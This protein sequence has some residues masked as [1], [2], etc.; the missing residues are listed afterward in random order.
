MSEIS[1]AIERCLVTTHEV[2]GAGD[3]GGANLADVVN[4]LA[5]A[6]TGLS[7]TIRPSD[8][9]IGQDATGTHVTSVIEAVMGVTS[10]L[11]EIASAIN[12]LAEAVKELPN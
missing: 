6:I 4:K 9:S 12:K 7:Y 3:D 2:A 11:C 10:G 5:V 8:A 1:E